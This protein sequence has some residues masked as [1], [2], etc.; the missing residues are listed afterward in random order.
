MYMGFKV[1]GTIDAY[2]VRIN[3]KSWVGRCDHSF[4]HTLV[5]TPAQAMLFNQAKH[6]YN[7][8]Q[9]Y[10]GTPIQLA[11]FQTVTEADV[12]ADDDE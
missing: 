1:P 5:D 8:A 3:D 4:D 12:D 10:G 6:A 11:L 9:R 7:V 2:I